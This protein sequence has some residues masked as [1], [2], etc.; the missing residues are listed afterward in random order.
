VLASTVPI[1]KANPSNPFRVSPSDDHSTPSLGD[2]NTALDHLLRSRA[3]LQDI[4]AS[5]HGFWQHLAQ[6]EVIPVLSCLPGTIYDQQCRGI[7]ARGSGVTNEW[8]YKLYN[9]SSGGVS[10]A[11]DR[12]VDVM[13][14]GS[15]RYV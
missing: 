5:L 15:L 10:D 7:V 6:E 8:H 3:I 9:V 14:H 11:L 12:S 2:N 4:C 1:T 13:D